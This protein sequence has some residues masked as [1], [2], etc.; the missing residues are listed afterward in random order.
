ML[1]TLAGAA[2]ANDNLSKVVDG[3][4]IYV[5]IVPAEIVRGHPKEHPEGA[6]HGGVPLGAE[7]YHVMVA[8]FDAKTGQRITDADVKAS[9]A[10]VGMTGSPVT[11]EPMKIADTITYGNYFNMSGYGPFRI[12]LQIKRP[13]VAR[14]IE[15]RFE[16]KHQ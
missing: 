11:L 13:D 9:V 10:G 8:L 4:T 1:S 15:A 6:M 7:Q 12:V 2:V 5:G 16:H 14:V 3:V